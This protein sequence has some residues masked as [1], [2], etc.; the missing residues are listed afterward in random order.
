MCLKAYVTLHQIIL[1]HVLL[2]QAMIHVELLIDGSWS[3]RLFRVNPKGYVK[4]ART[5]PQNVNAVE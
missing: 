3:R 2:I 4:R 5:Q 1:F